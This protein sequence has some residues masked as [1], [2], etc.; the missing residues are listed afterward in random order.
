MG[1]KES[2][3][4]VKTEKL[5]SNIE[6]NILNNAEFRKKKSCIVPFLLESRGSF[7]AELSFH[8]SL[9]VFASLEAHLGLRKRGVV[10]L[11]QDCKPL[12]R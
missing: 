1:G 8:Y 2:L 6:R 7:L 3:R 9:C 12:Q 11:E 4:E 5:C 10:F